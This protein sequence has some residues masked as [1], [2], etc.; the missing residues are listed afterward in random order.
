M[1]NVFLRGSNI[2]EI[3]LFV[4]KTYKFYSFTFDIAKHKTCKIIQ[5][6]LI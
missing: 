2:K 4:E 3:V 1:K 6:F 5:H